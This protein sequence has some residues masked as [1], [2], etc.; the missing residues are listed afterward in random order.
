M[1]YVYGIIAGMSVGALLFAALLYWNPFAGRD[2]VSPLAVAS[3]RLLELKYSLAAVDSIAYVNDG[4]SSSAPH[5]EKIQ[6]LWEPTVND[7]TVLVAMLSDARGAPAGIGVKFST[8]SEASRLLNAEV[9]VDSVWHVWLADRGGMLIQQ[10][11]NRWPWLRDVVI[12]ATL[13]SGDSWRGNWYGILTS[14]PNALGTGVVSA[15]GINGEAVE[16]IKANAYSAD[17]GPVDV[18]GSLTIVLPYAES[19]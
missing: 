6:Q 8:G 15:G 2:A 16:A 18:E 11:E 4:R 14:G 19:P 13:S 3:G 12:P 9:L 10:T 7:T 1:K 5:P 17:R